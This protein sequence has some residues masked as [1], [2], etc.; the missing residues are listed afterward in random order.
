MLSSS[1]HIKGTYC[2]FDLC[3]LVFT[4]ITR[5]K[6]C[7]SVSHCKVTFSLPFPYCTSFGKEVTMCSS[8]LGSGK[9]CSSSFSEV[10]TQY[11]KFFCSGN[12]SLYLCT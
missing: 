11:L 9:L 4:L 12:L 5:L 1:P 3:F 6:L 10:A 2:Q 8:Q 7:L